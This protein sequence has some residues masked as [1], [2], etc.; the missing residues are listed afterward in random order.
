MRRVLKFSVTLFS[1]KY[2]YDIS[3]KYIEKYMKPERF[4][5]SSKRILV[6]DY[7]K[8]KQKQGIKREKI[9]INTRQILSLIDTSYKEQTKKKI[10]TEL[11]NPISM[12]KLENANLYIE[13]RIRGIT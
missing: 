9:N 1:L 3:S 5:H 12:E 4:P 11:I 13:R 2:L 7:V 10:N 6:L 8:E